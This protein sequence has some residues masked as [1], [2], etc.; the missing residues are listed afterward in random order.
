MPD[1]RLIGLVAIAFVASTVITGVIFRA[2]EGTRVEP[3]AS[4]VPASMQCG[5][6]DTLSHSFDF[7]VPEELP[8]VVIRCAFVAQPAVPYG[9]APFSEVGPG[10]YATVVGMLDDLQRAFPDVRIYDLFELED[11]SAGDME[12]VDFTD[13][14]GALVGEDRV[15][16]YDTIYA[17]STTPDGDVSFYRGIRDFF[18]ERAQTVFTI[19]LS[20]QGESVVYSADVDRTDC[21]PLSEAPTGKVRLRDLTAG[22]KV[23]LEVAAHMQGMRCHL[24]S[25][26]VIRLDTG[27]G[28]GSLILDHIGFTPIPVDTG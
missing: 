5:S 12:M 8:D 13:M 20:R 15:N 2:R 28:M 14:M 17:L 6:R 18:Y 7:M 10:Q 25:M 27:Y 19:E 9:H 24:G 26:R 11:E 4:Q 1:R 22:E 21:L 16:D 3:L 23:H